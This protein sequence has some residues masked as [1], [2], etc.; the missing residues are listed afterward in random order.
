MRDCLGSTVAV[1]IRKV[2]RTCLSR[3]FL[4]VSE[5][6]V[7]SFCVA[8]VA[9][10]D[11]PRVCGGISARDRREAKVAVSMGKVARTCLSRVF[12]DVSEDVVMPF[13]V[14]GVSLC[15]TK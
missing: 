13:C 1:L 7:M 6:V 15:S 2:A 4:D 3:V 5:D 9:L 8:S 14:A 12:L 11:I 10:C